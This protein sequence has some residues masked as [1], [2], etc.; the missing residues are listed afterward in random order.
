MRRSRRVGDTKMAWTIEANGTIKQVRTEKQALELGKILADFISYVQVKP[1]LKKGQTGIGYVIHCDEVQAR[2]C[3]G[4]VQ[5]FEGKPC[6]E[7]Y[8]EWED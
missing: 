4:V 8:V 7:I 2:N 6:K 5:Y 1:V 3:R